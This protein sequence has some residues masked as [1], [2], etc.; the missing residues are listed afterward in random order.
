[1][2]KC[3]EPSTVVRHWDVGTKKCIFPIIKRLKIHWERA[4]SLATVIQC[5][6]C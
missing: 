6:G 1:M 2:A 3:Y 5:D 4:G